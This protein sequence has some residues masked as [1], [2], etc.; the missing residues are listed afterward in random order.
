MALMVLNYQNS[1][2]FQETFITHP[3]QNFLVLKDLPI[4]KKNIFF[5]GP[6]A[7]LYHRGVQLGSWEKR[8]QAVQQFTRQ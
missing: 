5:Q 6:V 1:K 3:I 4:M 2:D 8:E 7:P